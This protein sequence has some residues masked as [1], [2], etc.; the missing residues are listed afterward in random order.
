[1]CNQCETNPVYEFTN[2]RKL[3]K[4]CFVRWFQKKFFYTIRKFEMINFG[5]EIG[6]ENNGNFRDAVLVDL[7]KIYSEKGSAEVVKI[8]SK[9]RK[10]AVSSTTDSEAEE[11]I[12]ILVVGSAENLKNG[13]V[14]K[15][16]GKTI[17]KPLYLF[18]DKEV[19]LYAKLRRLK[20]KKSVEKEDKLSL[21]VEEL[22][23]KHPEIMQSVIASYGEIFGDGK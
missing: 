16:N 20:F 5:E 21:F 18:L 15:I 8:N 17:I 10:I 2:K 6:F 13:A 9:N 1:M 3:C 12:H 11:I 7:L 4:T 14:E 22:E 19:L 23:K